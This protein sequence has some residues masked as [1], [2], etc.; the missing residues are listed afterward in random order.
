V[1]TICRIVCPAKVRLELCGD[2]AH[3][4]VN[5]VVAAGAGKAVAKPRTEPNIA[6]T[7]TA[8]TRAP[9]FTATSQGASECAQGESSDSVRS[10]KEFVPLRPDFAAA[11]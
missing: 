2:A 1:C 5:A 8:V 10:V 4:P 9:I 6:K 3:V 11:I 7:V